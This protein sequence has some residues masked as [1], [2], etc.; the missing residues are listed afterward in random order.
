MRYTP[1]VVSYIP[2]KPK[3]YEKEIARNLV[4]RNGTLVIRAEFVQI[5][6]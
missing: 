6:L 1:V 2:T 5:Y 3:F 4:V